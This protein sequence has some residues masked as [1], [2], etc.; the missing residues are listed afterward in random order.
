MFIVQIKGI[1]A[2]TSICRQTNCCSQR[3]FWS[4]FLSRLCSCHIYSH[5]VTI[6]NSWENFL[7]SLKCTQLVMTQHIDE[8]PILIWSSLNCRC[9]PIIISQYEYLIYDNVF[10]TEITIWRWCN[11]SVC[12]LQSYRFSKWYCFRIMCKC[13]QN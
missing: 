2:E 4:Y 5:I 10:G 8:V 3:D 13:K 9:Q 11:A 12:S 6:R 1:S 7:F